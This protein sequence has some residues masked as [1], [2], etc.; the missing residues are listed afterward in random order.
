MFFENF[1]EILGPVPPELTADLTTW[2]EAVNI[3]QAL[4][5]T[6]EVFNAYDSRLIVVIDKFQPG[7]AP[8]YARAK[9]LIDWLTVNLKHLDYPVVPYRFELSF[10]R[11][12]S[13]VKEHYDVFRFHRLCDRIHV[14][15][16]TTGSKFTGR[17]HT[18]RQPHEFEVKTG[19]YFRL[20]NRVPHS[21]INDTDQIRVHAILDFMNVHDV[22]R[23]ANLKP[24]E[25]RVL[26]KYTD[27][28]YE[29]RFKK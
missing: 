21:A 27:T 19:G 13:L 11:P 26:D 6:E 17:W 22:E 24:I 9:P 10:V 5:R 4:P 16:V 1:Y 20:N 28:D 7:Y 12:H 18:S 15:L 25:Y 29:V 23:D 2:C 3:E 14:P 8:A